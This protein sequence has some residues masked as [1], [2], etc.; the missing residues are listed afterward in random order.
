MVDV[1]GA[2]LLGQVALETRRELGVAPRQLADLA[3]ERRGEEHRLAVAGEAADDPI[4]LRLE[5]HVEHPVGLVE[6]EDLDRIERDQLAVEEIL[7]A[8]R[9]RDE[10]LRLAGV[11]GLLAE[12]HAAVD[13][14]GAQPANRG[15]RLDRLRHLRGQLAG[16]HEHERADG[17]RAA[18]EPLDD[19]DA[20]RE[21]LT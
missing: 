8:A 12:R 7:Q 21:G 16:R 20:E 5:A 9:R 18:L 19:R 11:L 1:A 2:P 4:D 6:H 15:D 13:G 10:D 3:V 17:G 14:D